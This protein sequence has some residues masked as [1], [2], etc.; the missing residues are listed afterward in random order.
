M[1][2]GSSAQCH[3]KHW[4]NHTR[5]SAAEAFLHL[6]ELPPRDAHEGIL[7]AAEGLQKE[8][9]RGATGAPRRLANQMK[10]KSMPRSI[11]GTVAGT[12]IVAVAGTGLILALSRRGWL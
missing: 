2:P 11:A 9:R 1:S 5:R 4:R 10:E 8:K 7:P 12:G 3:G 6:F